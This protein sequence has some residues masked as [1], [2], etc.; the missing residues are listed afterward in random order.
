MIIEDDRDHRDVVRE[1]LDQIIEAH[2]GGIEVRS[3]PG[4]G[5]TFLV[6]LPLGREARGPQRTMMVCRERARMSVKRSWRH[7]RCQPVGARSSTA[8]DTLPRVDDSQRASAHRIRAHIE[9][10]AGDASRFRAAFSSV[11]PAE[12]DAWLDLVLGLDEIPADGPALPRGC[13]P[14]LPC[15][16]ATVLRVVQEAP[17]R[18]SDVFVDVGAGLGR[19]ATLV[20]LLTGASA[21]GLEIQPHLVRAARDLA[22]RLALPRVAC[23]EGDAATLA[24]RIPIGSVFFLYCPFGGDRL[25]RVLDDLE[26]IARTR[27]LRVCTVDLPLP[28]RPWLTPICSDAGDLAIYRS[29]LHEQTLGRGPES[30]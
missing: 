18:A 10:G 14:Y 19:T 1:V 16:V 8:C 4:R 9:R 25:I 12:R 20:H 22:A 23:V 5:A 26:Q 2:G 29:T 28:P 27:P 21:V 13:V 17:V 6:R 3:E 24:G 15:P 7:L 30:R 11:P